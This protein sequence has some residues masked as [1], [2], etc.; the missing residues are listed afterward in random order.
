MHRRRRRVCSSARSRRAE[1]MPVS[2]D[3]FPSPITSRQILFRWRSGNRL[4]LPGAWTI[5]ASHRGKDAATSVGCL[6]PSKTRFS[7]DVLSAGAINF[8]DACRRIPHPR[9]R[10]RWEPQYPRYDN[11]R[12]TIRAAVTRR[13][14]SRQFLG[15]DDFVQTKPQ[16]PAVS[17]LQPENLQRGDS[18]AESSGFELSVP[19]PERSDY[20]G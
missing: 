17:T 4:G 10:S 8:A 15:G 2:A 14:R 3:T 13:G 18:L 12:Q 5:P 11:A 7:G 16:A 1:L 19:A 6:S 20:Q 9:P